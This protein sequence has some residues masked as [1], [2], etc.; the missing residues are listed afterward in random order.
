[1]RGTVQLVAF[2][3]RRKAEFAMHTRD[4]HPSAIH[5]PMLA[6]ATKHFFYF[7]SVG[8]IILTKRFSFVMDI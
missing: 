4:L 7:V 5:R 3:R 1:M 2:V 6:G 8:A